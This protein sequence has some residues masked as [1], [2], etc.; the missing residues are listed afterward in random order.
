MPEANLVWVQHDL[1]CAIEQL[2]ATIEGAAIGTTH[3][4][5]VIRTKPK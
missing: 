2:V 5:R 4:Y 3:A 1:A